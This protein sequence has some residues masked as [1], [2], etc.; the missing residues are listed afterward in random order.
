MKIFNHNQEMEILVEEHDKLSDPSIPRISAK[1][2]KQVHLRY[3]D[4][5]DRKGMTIGALEESHVSIHDKLLNI[6]TNSKRKETIWEDDNIE[7]SEGDVENCI[8]DGSPSIKF[9]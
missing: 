9:S 4:L 6:I 5:L 1:V 3:E 7:L 2:S 8:I